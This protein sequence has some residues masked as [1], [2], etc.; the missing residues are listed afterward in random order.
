MWQYIQSSGE[1]I[2]ASGEVVST[3]YSGAGI[4]K[5]N[6]SMQD[7]VDVGPCPV[8]EYTLG[9]PVNSHVHGP[10]AIPLHPDIENEMFGRDGFMCHG[11][12]VVNPGTASEGCVI[13][14]YDTRVQMWESED[15]RLQVIP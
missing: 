7:V 11:D 13:Q 14:P 4:G 2:S 10:Y 12:S 6:P 15:H 3:G 1:M 8:G 9:E 5:N